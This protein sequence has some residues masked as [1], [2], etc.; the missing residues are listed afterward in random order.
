MNNIPTQLEE[1]KN[2]WV[3]IIRSKASYE[4]NE[5]KA[6]NVVA[7]PSIDDICNEIEAFFTALNLLPHE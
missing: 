4:H 5:R 7:S 6:G 1:L 3:R 2:R